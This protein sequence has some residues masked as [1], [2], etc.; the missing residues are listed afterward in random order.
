MT[1]LATRLS[2]LS[3]E[4]R[5]VL[6]R[7][8]RE[9]SAGATPA[10]PAIPRWTGDRAPLS[11]AQERIWFLERL[12]PGTALYVIGAHFRLDG[13]LDAAAL[14]RALDAL[15]ERH[16]ALRSRITLRDGDLEQRMAPP[17]PVAVA[18]VDLG[19]LP[20]AARDAEVSRLTSAEVRRP[21]DVAAEAPFRATLARLGPDQ[22]VLLLTV[23]HVVSDGWSMGIL[24]R[25]LEVL[26]GAFRRGE[27]SPLV[28]PPLSFASF[29][30]WQR[31][32]LTPEALAPDLSFWRER[33]AGAPPLLGFATDRPRPAV[34]GHRGAAE[35][36][37]LP[38]AVA[39]ALRARCREEG[40]TLFAGLLAG[41]AAL[42]QRHGGGDELVIGTPVAGRGRTELE[43]VVGPFINT[44]ALRL[45]LSS[46]PSLRALARRAHE[47]TAAALAHAE[48]PFEKLVEHLAPAR[49][50]SHA[51]L[52]QA[53]FTLHPGG[54]QA[55]SLPGLAVT[56]LPVDYAGIDVDLGLSLTDTPGALRGELRYDVALFEPATIQRL[57]AHLVTLLGRAVADADA[58]LLEIP[59][60]SPAERALVLDTYNRTEL[61]YDRD[62]CVHD[63]VFAEAGRSGEAIAVTCAGAALSYRELA[64]RARVLSRRL[65]A[66]GIGRGALVG[67]L[68]PRSVDMV[69]AVLG[70]LAS[71]AA[72]VPLDPRYPAERLAFMIADARLSA[73]L[74]ETEA[75]ADPGGPLTLAVRG[76][77][78][79][80]EAEPPSRARPGDPAY[81]IYT[82]GSTGRPKGVVVPHRGVVNFLTHMAREPGLS[83]ADTLLAVTTLSFDIAALEIF[84]PLT[85]GARVEIATREVAADGARL[86]DLVAAS[87]C[88]VL[89]ATPATYQMLLEAGFAGG[90]RLRLLCG[91]EALQP[92]LARRLRARCGSLHNLY[93]PTETTIWST[94]HHVADDGPVRVGR[95]IANTR[96]YVLDARLGP[97]PPGVPGEVFIGG[98]GVAAGYLG[99]PELT[100]TRFLPDPFSP[101][102]GARMYRTGDRGRH[103]PGGA[104]EILGRVDHQVK[105]RG[106]RIELGEIDAALLEH[107]AVSRAVTVATGD[108][109][110]ALRLVAYFVAADASAPPAA[111][112]LGRHL[113]AKLPEYMVPAVFVALAALP[114]LPN[115]KLDRAAL[116]AP[117][118]G[119]AGAH[120]A[121][122]TPDEEALAAIWI[123]VLRLDR[124]GV[125]DD[126]F[127]L[128]GHSL[129]AARLFDRIEK[130]LGKS[131]PA[132]TLFQAPT[133][134]RLAAALR[135]ASPTP[136]VAG[137]LP[138]CLFALRRA[139]A[140]PPLFLARPAVRSSGA[141]VYAALA[142]HVDPDRPVYAFVN[143]PFLDGSP[144]YA[145]V[146]AMAA[147]AVSAMRVVAPRRPCLVGGWSLGGKTAFEIAQR[148]VASGERVDRLL[149]FDPAAPTPIRQQVRFLGKR[150][151]AQL[152]LRL[153]ARFP[154][155]VRRLP[156]AHPIH[157]WSPLLRFEGMAYLDL[158]NDD[159]GLVEHVFPGM[160]DRAVLR[161]LSPA[162]MW[163]HVYQVVRAA[164]P[165]APDDG[166][167]GV[168]VRRG[169]GYM[170]QD[171]VMNAR[172]RPR[173]TYPGATA[174]FV[175]RGD[176]VTVAR[177]QPFF[178][179]PLAVFELDLQVTKAAPTPHQAM[180][181]P[182]NAAVLG[183]ALERAVASG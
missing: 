9:K 140:K 130:Q 158:A 168:A 122:R 84:L 98:D 81:V 88:T 43:G 57:A 172:Y 34:A 126:F 133:I 103:L 55:L 8:L 59:L 147:D 29:A 121:P 97:V 124:V 17:G 38:E 136:A 99:R 51:P 78:G 23:H 74:A 85:T 120:L 95:P 157:G 27:A 132:V 80:G 49:D 131:L 22:H 75:A 116:P 159:V 135:E 40:V 70:V 10:L 138:A 83:R 14:G 102:P 24:L 87:G 41:F 61:A 178:A 105:V 173:G 64:E 110:S 94:V 2:R 33:L 3:P 145:S 174:I 44:V 89:Q 67:V 151:L 183:E 26:Y 93:G 58:P 115:G 101:V 16:E 42:L 82:S 162:A 128:G 86:R 96:V 175:P 71:G 66:L 50:T 152:R 160:F 179:R 11:F 118:A 18:T 60:L 72:Y 177:W 68:V 161:A 77:P 4:K 45:D 92:D 15:V 32:R 146:E 56:R 163:D 166:P 181:T 25:E 30:A 53:L 149:L 143:R 114:L 37:V 182:V 108:G 76:A 6:E 7:L 28:T 100:A 79:A 134:E 107:P 104:L 12:A 35:P 90:P 5:A 48:L 52:F 129:L 139:G 176:T 123:E 13:P 170:A 111:A 119:A 91:G 127:A 171:H 39:A 31:A 148:L 155:L 47:V 112:E 154:D 36:V 141:L 63:L 69:V 1:D 19:A 165:G 137:G 62:A 167:D 144:P 54:D 20:A 153:G 169:Y 73:V 180:L 156:V 113:R 117:A 21:F 106:H 164:E 65:A 46:D 109:A 125:R 150:A 142:L